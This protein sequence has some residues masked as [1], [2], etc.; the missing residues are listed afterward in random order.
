MEK[1]ITSREYAVFL[2]ELRAARKRRGVTQVE[3]AG[4]LGETQTF[5]SKVERGE[6]RLDVIELR[7]F[8]Q[9]LQLPLTSF[10]TDLEKLLHRESKAI[11]KKQSGGP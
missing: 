4:R 2:A 11:R 5:V 8:C 6:R 10:V 7:R 1:S 3:M 9:A